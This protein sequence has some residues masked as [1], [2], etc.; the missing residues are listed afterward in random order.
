MY[1]LRMSGN[2]HPLF[3]PFI[4]PFSPFTDKI[5][6][7]TSFPF[8]KVTPLF[9]FAKT[10]NY[11]NM[12]EYMNNIDEGKKRE[13]NRLKRSFLPGIL[14]ILAGVFLFA[15]KYNLFSVDI[16]YIV[17][18]WPMLLVVIGL[19]SFSGKGISRTGLLLVTIGGFF[20]I[21]R[22]FNLS[23]EFDKMFWPLL[24]ISIGI[25][26][27]F[28]QNKKRKHK[29]PFTKDYVKTND[30]DTFEI[31]AI[32]GGGERIVTTQ[33]LKGGAIT[34]I[35]GGA[36]ISLINC[37]LSTGKNIITIEAIMG[38]ATLIIPSDWTVVSNV[39]A[40][41][42]GIGDKRT[43]LGIV[44]SNLPEKTLYLEGTAIM[45]GIEIKSY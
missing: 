36:E 12:N 8:P 25:I 9:T 18:S 38:G 32:L 2:R 41:L 44:P 28:S 19:F 4:F 24:L 15:D 23:L 27:I 37:T 40:I 21:P 39:N 11:N 22:I 30:D 13:H 35:M 26:L 45:G 6:L 14:L 1:F 42:G 34:C 31:N 7:V 5:E 3:F 10:K 17:F 43:R 20:L 16:S 33:Q 29:L